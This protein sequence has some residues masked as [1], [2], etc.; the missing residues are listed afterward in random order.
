[1]TRR[2]VASLLL[3]LFLLL[4]LW[5]ELPSAPP[6]WWDEGWTLSAARNWVMQGHYGQINNGELLSPGLSAAFSVVAPIALSFKLFGIGVWQGR[7]PGV[8]CAFGAI[9][10]LHYLA[11][12]L[13]GDKV[14]NGTLFVLFLMMASEPLN[15]LFIGRQVLGE[16]PMMFYLLAGHCL[17]FGAIRGSA[18]L[19]IPAILFWSIAIR[20]KAQV[21]AF[22]FAS[23]LLPLL[24]AVYRRWWK[25]ASLLCVATVGTWLTSRVLVSWV[26]SAIVAGQTAPGQPVE[27][28][29]SVLVVVPEPSVR[30]VA[31]R[32]TLAYGLP[33]LVGI[34]RAAWK[35]LRN[36][37]GPEI[38]P[39]KEVIR[40]ALL[41][42][43]GGWLAWYLALG[44]YW[45]RY[46]FPALFVGGVFASALL[47]DL[48]KGFNLRA[49]FTQAGGIFRPQKSQRVDRRQL[50]VGARSFALLLWGLI[51][52]V[53]TVFILF[54]MYFPLE[55]VSASEVASYLNEHTDPGTLIETYESELFMFLDRAYHYPP[56]QISLELVRRKDIDPTASIDYDPL[57]ADPDYLVVGRYSDEWSLYNPW[58]ETGAFR[59]LKVYPSYRIYQRN[60][61]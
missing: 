4:A 50:L 17:L 19:V 34:G 47:Y 9:M 25:L 28:A 29:L 55:R 35:A 48:T 31:L 24:L 27:G 61:D 20:T 8:L 43:A 49:A 6:L 58:L 38:S 7:L 52:V 16:M 40:W 41:G 60:R 12:Q 46:A 53:S 51:T 22:W 30:L 32:V 56:D 2:S 21:P 45:D 23:I 39:G 44:M 33:A 18:W 36:L 59:L 54:F 14:A 10:L 3:C 5:V 1:M 11:V 42:L 26:E 37:R 15:P 57:E 13:Y